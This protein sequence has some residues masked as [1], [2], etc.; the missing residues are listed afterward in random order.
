M[1]SINSIDRSY[2]PDCWSDDERMN[3]LFNPFRIREVNP[4]GWDL[5]MN[6]WINLI[7][8]WCLSQ[9]KL[10]FTID[11]LR[12]S[13]IRNGR[14]P[15][16]DCIQLVVSHMKREN[17]IQ[18]KTELNKN[19][20]P[21]WTGWFFNSLTKIPLLKND[22]SIKDKIIDIDSN[23][24][25]VNMEI[26][27]NI[28]QNIEAYIRKMESSCI[29]YVKFLNI[30]KKEIFADKMWEDQS[31]EVI[32]KYLQCKNK[33]KI[34]EKSGFKIVEI[35]NPDIENI[36]LVVRDLIRD[37]LEDE[38]KDLEEKLNKLRQQAK[39]V[40]Q[41]GNKQL[42]LLLLKRK[43]KLDN[44]VLQKYCQLN[45]IEEMYEKIQ[46]AISQ[47]QIMQANELANNMFKA[48]KLNIEDVENVK[49]ELEE[50]MNDVSDI[51]SE[52]S[53]PNNDLVDFDE[54]QELK[55]LLEENDDDNKN[56]PQTPDDELIE[57]MGN[58]TVINNEESLDTNQ[59][60]VAKPKQ[61]EIAA[62]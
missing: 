36:S 51:T 61:F 46:E 55:D 48:L 15:H 33:F 23:I 4:E 25:L 16:L 24:A 34:S 20:A 2:L 44:L 42:A 59:A 50:K 12:K 17:T 60:K 28:S 43:K 22:E 47:K 40:L 26:L 9:R 54:E 5:K 1:H 41:N 8:K 39:V 6:F 35:G 21:T 14:L 31:L 29:G 62:E 10:V 3:V 13:F 27:E 30:L 11:E 32:L 53:R 18:Y 56:K 45:N 38:I 19:N 37:K 57:L 58:L 52:L 49:S 7:N